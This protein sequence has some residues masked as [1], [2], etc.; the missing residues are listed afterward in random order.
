MAIRSPICTVVG[1]VDHGKSSILDWI[2]G[3]KIVEGE[4]G[5]IT[6]SIGASNVPLDEIKRKCASLFSAVKTNFTIPGLLFID[7]PGHAAFTNM[8]KRG[9]NLADIA[10]LVVDINEGFMPQTI[11]AMEILRSYK[12]PFVIA[13]NK[14]DLLPGWQQKEK[15]LLPD[16]AAQRPEVMAEFEKKMYELVGKIYDLTQ[17]ESER[18]DRVSDYTK[19]IAL[20]PCSARTGEGLSE[21]LFTVMGLAQKYLENKLQITEGD[22]KAIVLEVKDVKGLGKSLDVILY[23]GTLKTGDAIVIGGL[24]GPITTKVKAIFLASN[25]GELR[26]K[27]TK[28]D[29]VK[30]VVAAAGVRIAANDIDNVVGGM[31]MISATKDGLEA[32][33]EEVQKEIEEVTLK[34]DGEGVVIK[35]D[36]LGSLEAM[37]V[38]LKEKKIPIAIAS[39]GNVNKKDIT[40]AASNYEKDPFTGVVLGFN[41]SSDIPTGH[42]KV[43]TNQVIYRL[44]EEYDAWKI[45]QEKALEQKEME[46]LVR[47]CKVQLLKNYIFRQSGPAVIGCEVL[48]GTLVP[49]TPLMIGGKQVAVV[50]SIKSEKENLTELKEGKQA[51][52]SMDHVII[53]RT[54]QGDEMMYS[55]IPANDFKKM[56]EFKKAL[57]PKEIQLLKE[58]AVI[59]RL[60]NPVWGI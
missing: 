2:R 38:L 22:A 17:M 13:V 57:T 60:D 16:I 29:S 34:A 47:P 1:H 44:L 27:K 36:S 15:L 20:I 25:M 43:L 37:M 42:V 18:F 49:G 23:D 59:M 12:T 33:K 41:V 55:F 58:I 45:E 46:G 56:K 30:E 39:I 53:G 19:Q 50:K 40:T 5:G 51:A 35:A 52:I 28:F 26:D 9:G 8:R 6:Q 54:L 21:L 31:P 3:S 32:A 48:A 11:E 7:T 4:V 14:L 10:I 24:D